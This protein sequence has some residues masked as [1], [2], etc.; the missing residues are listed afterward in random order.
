MTGEP[1]THLFGSATP[2]VGAPLGGGATTG[3][4]VRAVTAAGGFGFLPAG[5]KTPDALAADL[6]DL[7]AAGTPYGVNLFVPG[8]REID[9][10]TFRRYARQIAAEGEPYGLDL[11]DAPLV[12]DDDHWAD[13]VDL[14]VRHPV[15]VV[16]FT[17][18]LP[19]PAALAALRRAGS[20]LLVTVTSVAEALAARDLGVDG[21]V[22]QG[23]EAGGHSGTHTPRRP[24]PPTSTRPLVRDVAAATGL[25]VVA[26]GGVAGPAD[27]RDLLA[28][29]A[30]A[31]AVGTLLLRTD[32]SGASRT[33]RDALA[34]PARTSTVLTR[35]LTGR[36]ARGL[37]NTF[38]DRY[39]PVAPLGYPE[40]HH[41]TRGMRAAAAAAGHPDRVHLWAGTGYRHAGTGPAAAVVERLTA[42]L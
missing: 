5:Y 18:G 27:V 37:R 32:E 21:L 17:F 38:I 22:A 3:A 39:E 23:T 26:A 7:H 40:L 8:P 9:E 16:S 1:W 28:A 30:S 29:G 12:H 19:D 31:V 42:A 13:K 11:A 14:L 24:A 34:D 20:R 33:H 15:P 6:A 2:I 10:T 41:L 36:P 25:P 4:L 35:A